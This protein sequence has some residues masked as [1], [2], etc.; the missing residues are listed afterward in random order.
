LRNS[1]LR[2]FKKN[3]KFHPTKKDE[4]KKV[5]IES[6]MKVSKEI[7]MKDPK[8][9]AF[10]E[11]TKRRLMQSNATQLKNVKEVKIEDKRVGES[12][13]EKDP[14]KDGSEKIVVRY[15][16]SNS[17]QEADGLL[18]HELDHVEWD[19]LE[20]N[21]PEK[22]HEFM[23]AVIEQPPFT[24]DL[25]TYQKE[26]MEAKP[27]DIDELSR[28]YFD[29]YHSEIGQVNDRIKLGLIKRE[30]IESKVDLTKI[31]EAYNQ[32]HA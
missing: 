22:I 9:V 28:K 3:G 24:N 2:G 26:L 17:P 14:Q 20:K 10:V 11:A 21:H 12:L 8:Q 4:Q 7:N 32:L 30:D 29:E 5:D 6:I 1:R 25:E 27:E 18:K 19:E 16:P 23:L 15:S 13:A 31:T